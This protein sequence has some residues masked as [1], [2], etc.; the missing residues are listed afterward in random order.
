[1]ILKEF[2]IG[3]KLEFDLKCVNKN[4]DCEGVCW[5]CI[6]KIWKR[7]ILIYKKFKVYLF[8]II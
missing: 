2:I 5:N 4:Y 6:L 1:M 3:L 8:I 7:L